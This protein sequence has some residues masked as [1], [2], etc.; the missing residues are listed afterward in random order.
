MIK[1]TDWD[2]KEKLITNNLQLIKDVVC[3]SN[4]QPEYKSLILYL[5]IVSYSVKFYLNEETKDVME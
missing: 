4:D 5:M 3:C 1:E 2:I